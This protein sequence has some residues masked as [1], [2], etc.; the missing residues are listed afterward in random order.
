MNCLVDYLCRFPERNKVPDFITLSSLLRITTKYEMP[1][2]RSQLLEV[3]RGA[4]PEIFEGL[5][6]SQPLGEKAFSGPTPHPNAALNSFVQQNL[7]S[8]LPMAARSDVDSLT[9]SRHLPRNATLSPPTIQSAIRR[10]KPS[11]DELAARMAR[12]RESSERIKQ[13]RLVCGAPAL[14]LDPTDTPDP[15]GG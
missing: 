7:T 5:A 10:E 11:D 1:A 14:I 12:I 6:P 15:T 4:Y 3:V 13:R 8:A 2:V 9:D